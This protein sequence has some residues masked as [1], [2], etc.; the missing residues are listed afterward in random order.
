[1]LNNH[2]LIVSVDFAIDCLKYA[3][4]EKHYRIKNDDSRLAEM[5]QYLPYTLQETATNGIHI[6]L[7]RQYQLLGSDAKASIPMAK[8]DDYTNAH[9][10]LTSAQADS[11]RSNSHGL[12]SDVDAP[13]VGK[14]QAKAYLIRLQDLHSIL[15]SNDRKIRQ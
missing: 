11:V 1:M 2:E 3:L 14:K 8:Y 10:G 15:I 6:L 5:R 12:Y 9:I 7:N 4:S 13:W